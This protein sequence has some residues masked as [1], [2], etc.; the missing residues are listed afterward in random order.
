MRRKASKLLSRTAVERADYYAVCA[1]LG[2]DPDAARRGKRRVTIWDTRLPAFGL[3]LLPSGRK[4]FVLH[5]KVGKRARKLTIGTTAQI[6]AD[7][8]RA[9]A[10]DALTQIAEGHDPM[11][12]KQTAEGL[13]VLRD[14]FEAF[15]ND[16][17][18]DGSQRSPQ[19]VTSYRKLF[20]RFLE[21]RLGDVRIDQLDQR[22]CNAA[23]AVALEGEDGGRHITQYN[24]TRALLAAIL[25]W[26]YERELIDRVPRMARKHAEKRRT[27]SA[28]PE[29][30]ARLSAALAAFEE[31]TASRPWVCA[32]LR[33]LILT[34]ARTGEIISLRW[35]DVDFDAAEFRPSAFKGMTHANAKPRVI[36]IT[37]EIEVL[38]R[39]AEGWRRPGNPHV[40]PGTGSHHYRALRKAWVEF[41]HGH[42][43]DWDLRVHDLRHLTASAALNEGAIPTEQIS[44]QLG[45]ADTAI[46][47]RYARVQP[48]A[49]REAAARISATVTRL[50]GD[51]S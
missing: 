32:I 38:L 3:C 7:R 47:Q 40:F 4:V 2:L 43:G 14:V 29:D 49:R 51:G 18:K 44:A 41:R 42:L 39:V 10:Q 6:T 22:L 36:P 15:L 20:E 48:D 8:A 33:M 11:A 9:M 21:P 5:Y 45:H 25:R 24:R 13:P 28:T 46:T 35:S 1:T 34:G 37:P 27:P 30:F 26:A 17:K 50:M 23:L 16:P 19:T 31:K 12:T